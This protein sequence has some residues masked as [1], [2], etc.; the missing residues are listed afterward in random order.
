MAA[1]LAGAVGIIAALNWEMDAFGSCPV[2]RIRYVLET[3]GPGA[4]AAAAGAERAVARGAACLVS[5]G[6]VGALKRGEP[7]DILLPGRVLD[8][9]LR[10]VETDAALS[11]RLSQAFHGLAPI[12][13]GTLA[14]AHAP[15]TTRAGKMA[16]AESSGADAV[17]MESAAIGNVA[18]RH[19]LPLLIV[20]VIVDRADK[21]VPA[22]AMA[23]MDGP[24]TRPARVL[25]RL[26]KS[27]HEV[28]DMFALALAARRA[29]RTLRACA[30][31][32]QAALE[33]DRSG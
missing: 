10:A 18:S 19:R 21:A 13:R 11:N 32:M 14:S 15:V 24:R 33:A 6:T 5:W 26:L 3:T 17:D 12:H 4:G 16:L 23:G 1:E 28:P 29:R 22:A 9:S 25:A 31:A 27:P 8:E 20:R 30:P 2:G 7:G